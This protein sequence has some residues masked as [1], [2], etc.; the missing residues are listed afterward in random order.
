[1]NNQNTNTGKTGSIIRLTILGLSLVIGLIGAIGDLF[2]PNGRDILQRLALFV[3]DIGAMG[4]TAVFIWF[5]IKWCAFLG[6][7]TLG[8]AGAFWNNFIALNLFT[9]F[10][11]ICIWL[12]IVIMPFTVGMGVLLAPVMALLFKLMELT[13][14][15]LVMLLFSTVSLA[16]TVFLAWLELKKLNWLPA[17]AT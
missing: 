6:S 7:R 9:L 1:M 10:V 3:G 5:S 14:N 12:A 17:K 15:F 13:D 11:K 16:V 8:W 4:L 2:A